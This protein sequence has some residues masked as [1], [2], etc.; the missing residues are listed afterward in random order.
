MG[1]EEKSDKD[2][3]VTAVPEKDLAKV[4]AVSAD[5]MVH[6]NNVLGSSLEQEIPSDKINSFLDA[7][8]VKKLKFSFKEIDEKK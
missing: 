4:E 2:I 3:V 8:R 5:G 7:L 6:L 1:K